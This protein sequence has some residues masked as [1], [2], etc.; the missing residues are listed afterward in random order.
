M[1]EIKNL[2]IRSTMNNSR[3]KT[4]DSALSYDVEQ[5]LKEGNIIKI[6]PQGYSMYPLFIPGR[7][8]AL[9]EQVPCQKLR[10]GDVVLY[11]R[12]HGILVIHRIC[13]IDDNGFYMVGDNQSE[14]EGPLRPDQ[15]RG[16]MIGFIRNE[17]KYS[18][19]NPI[20]R[21]F[22]GLWLILLPLRPFCFR[23]SAGMKKLFRPHSK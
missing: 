17:K 18:V 1:R 10:R 11:R 5:L 7:D 19:K 20:Y 15:I 21:F 3:A 14:I 12:D 22:S 6:Q 13:R 23:I 4:T 16:R 9:I 8:E 2:E